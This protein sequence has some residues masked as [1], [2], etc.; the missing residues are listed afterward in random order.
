MDHDVFD[1]NILESQIFRIH[2]S[3]NYLLTRESTK[4]EFKEN[5]NFAEIADY[6]K[7]FAA[8]SNN[9]GGYLVFGV[10]DSPHT[11]TGIDGSTF[12]K[13]DEQK[14]T[15]FVNEYFAPSIDWQKSVIDIAGK[16]FGRIYISESIDKPVIALKDGGRG[17]EIK[18]GEIYYRYTGRSQKIRYSELRQILDSK[19]TKERRAW[20]EH[21]ERMV[22][23]G[24]SNAAILDTVRGKIEGTS[25]IVLIDDELI[26]KL[27]FIREGQFVEKNGKPTLKLV[28]ELKPAS[29]IQKIVHDDPYKYRASDV[30]S[31]VQ[32]RL[33]K[34]FKAN[35]HHARAWK[36]FKI[37]TK[38]KDGSW[39]Y[40]SIYCDYKEAIKYFLYNQNWID[41]LVTE[42]SKPD[43][44]KAIVG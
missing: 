25:G 31:E 41:F 4:L 17:Q 36:Y 29:V 32:N 14:I 16:Q 3:G 26:P 1:K 30:A 8:F 40:D 22:K 23:I 7:D 15:G 35:P 42:L 5:F 6:L 34:P 44:Y 37:R 27:K 13:I 11:L 2:K 18:N 9:T 21:L 38:Q 39:K 12:D 19:L 28:G 10:E 43:T 24:P 20:Q 33:K